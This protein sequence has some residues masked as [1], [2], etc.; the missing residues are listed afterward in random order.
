MRFHK[1]ILEASFAGNMGFE[2]MVL[3]FQQASDKEISQME[4]VVKKADWNAFKKLIKKVT[5]EELK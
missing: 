4:K 1:F 3:F 5:G 2:E